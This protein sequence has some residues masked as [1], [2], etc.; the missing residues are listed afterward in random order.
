M[1][2]RSPK[3]EQGMMEIKQLRM[4]DVLAMVNAPHYL[5]QGR[6][7]I[8]RQRARAQAQNPCLQAQDVVL[9]VAEVDGQMAGYLGLVPDEWALGNGTCRLAWMSCIE[10][11]AAWQGRG[12]AKKLLASAMEAWDNQIIA[13]EFTPLALDIYLCSGFFTLISPNEG[14]RSYLR[15]CLS[16][17]LPAKN[18][19]WGRLKPLLRWADQAANSVWGAW[20][21]LHPPSAPVGME[22]EIVA[23]LDDECAAWLENYQH[24]SP[25]RKSIH[26][27]NWML[28]HPWVIQSP[29]G[30]MGTSKYGF[31]ALSPS[32]GY[33]A[34]KLYAPGGSMQGLLLVMV[35][36]GHVKTP[37]VAVAPALASKATQL[38]LY[39]A[40]TSR[41]GYITTYQPLITEH[42]PPFKRWSIAQKKQY[43]KYVVAKPLWEKLGK[44][45]RLPLHDGDGDA[46]FT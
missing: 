13:T 5:R 24:P 36:N 16:T 34:C 17:I 21:S 27:W 15:M 22:W 20:N 12:I 9:L 29:I 3:N 37:L 2:N 30:D 46:G 4:D 7:P 45:D 35:R 40:Y 41:A 25:A 6:I 42:L 38:L 43:R 44:P 28:R 18:P 26:G 19:L 23:H 8:G 14:I 1:D 10:V 32:F 11:G 33:L 39:L 31:T